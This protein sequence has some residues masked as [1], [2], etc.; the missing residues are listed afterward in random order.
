MGKTALEI[1]EEILAAR[2]GPESDEKRAFREKRYAALSK[3]TEEILE[4]KRKLAEERKAI[5]R[6]RAEEPLAEDE[7]ADEAP[8]T[9]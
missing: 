3:E 7:N 4:A 9:P 1:Y 2:R 5:L 6:R 8:E